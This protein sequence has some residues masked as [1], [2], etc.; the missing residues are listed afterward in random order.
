MGHAVGA[1]ARFSLRAC[2]GRDL[3]HAS[4]SDATV[5]TR[6]G[7]DA[8]GDVDARAGQRRPP[9]RPD[10]MAQRAGR[11]SSSPP[12]GPRAQIRAKVRGVEARSVRDM[13]LRQRARASPCS[14]AIALLLVFSGMAHGAL[15]SAQHVDAVQRPAFELTL[16]EPGAARR[17]WQYSAAAPRELRR[18]VLGESAV[19]IDKSLDAVMQ[20]PLRSARIQGHPASSAQFENVKRHARDVEFAKQKKRLVAEGPARFPSEGGG[21]CSRASGRPR[22]ARRRRRR[23]PCGTQRDAPMAKSR[24]ARVGSDAA[25]SGATFH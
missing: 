14:S 2:E 10:S 15:A 22:R 8:P 13:A 19:D 17:P 24:R 21:H 25:S 6:E 16:S 3:R 11:S 12:A 4:L 5:V 18:L 20:A 9:R 23:A 7:T 1:P